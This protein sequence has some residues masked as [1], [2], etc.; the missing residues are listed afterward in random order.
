MLFFRAMKSNGN[1]FPDCG[2]SS[3][4]LGVRCGLDIP[5]GL[6]GRVEPC[7]GGMSVFADPNRLPKHRKPYWLFGGEGR[8][9]LYSLDKEAIPKTL[10]SRQ[11]GELSH[12]LIEPATSVLYP[13]FVQA[14]YSTQRSWK[15][16]PCPSPL[17]FI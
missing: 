5:V 7:T 8:D 16:V 9:P 1:F 2:E 10:L 17:N 3:R 14:L 12:Y 13:V 11:N 4:Q 15:E 6:E